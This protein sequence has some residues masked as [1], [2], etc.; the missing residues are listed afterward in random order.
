MEQTL[1]AYSAVMFADVAGSTTLYEEL[2]DRQAKEIIGQVLGVAIA[3]TEKHAGVLVKTI[4]D[5]VMCRFPSADAAGR[6][7]IAIHE[8]LRDGSTGGNRV[9]QMRMGLHWGP[10]MYEHGDVFGDAVSVAARMSALAR[11]GQ[12]ITTHTTIH[13]MSSRLTERARVIDDERTKG[14]PG[15]AIYELVWEVDKVAQISPPAGERGIN[16][17]YLEYRDE[18]RTLG[19]SHQ[20]TLGRGENCD[21]FINSPLASRLHARI[22]SRHGKF[23]YSDQSTNGS[24]ILSDDGKTTY[25]KREELILSGHGTISLGESVKPGGEYLI[26][27]SVDEPTVEIK[28]R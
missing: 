12:I 8:A 28:H 5:E 15:Q 2:G 20:V 22:E 16:A 14:K 11:A 7:A 3:Q 23:V 9:M 19:N 4:G 25:L 21:L 24:F 27:Y 6:C 18:T 17:L 13:A 26:R 1:P 10:V